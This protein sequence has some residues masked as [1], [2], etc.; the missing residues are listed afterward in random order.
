[1]DAQ[2]ALFENDRLRRVMT[3]FG[4]ASD[5]HVRLW[6]CAL[7][8]PI[9]LWAPLVLLSAVQGL[10]WTQD[11]KQ[12]FLADFSVHMQML[13]AIPF[14]LFAE[15]FVEQRIGEAWL[16]LRDGGL[17][18][19]ESRQVL[20]DAAAKAMRVR[21]SIWLDML[22]YALG[23]AGAW[24]WLWQMKSDGVSTWHS[25]VDG[26]SEGLSL[27]GWWLG[28]V[29][30]P[31]LNYWYGR[32]LGKWAIWSYL[33]W[34]A[35]HTNLRLSAAHPDLSGGLSF[36]NRTQGSFGMIVF[37]IGMVVATTVGYLVGVAGLAAHSFA[38]WF[39]ITGF[40]TLGPTAFLLPLFFF[41]RQLVEA[42]TRGFVEYGALGLEY[43]EAFRSKWITGREKPNPLE[44]SA[45]IAGLCDLGQ[46]YENVR[47]M[48]V[49]P[50]DFNTALQLFG[51]A[52]GPLLP[53]L[54]RIFELPEPIKKLFGI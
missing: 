46:H 23:L 1:M 53:V 35:S 41:S 6:R 47:N 51:A 5:G 45:D 32:W 31:I 30:V 12:S 2:F 50:F 28:L 36:L 42:K 37:G 4:L 29:S 25:V 7:V 48:R 10:W 40:L 43:T 33:L 22:A 39:S 16:Q 34:S 3:R 27:A 44:A 26:P 11:L 52:L 13:V 8:L 19:P 24:I 20:L 49:V 54:L 15:E 18:S 9:V 17:V 14:F 21:D 38:V